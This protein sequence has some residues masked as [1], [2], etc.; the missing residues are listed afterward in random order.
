MAKRVFIIVL[1][2]F[3]IGQ[4]P[5]ANIYGDVGSNTLK[6]IASTTNLNIP[7]LTSLGLFNI[8][9]VSCRPKTDNPLGSYARLEE[10]SNGKDSTTGHWEMAGII[11]KTPFP[12]FKNGFPKSI[13]TKLEKAWNK[14]ILCNKP[15]S[16]TQVILDYGCEHIKTGNPIVYTSADSVLQIACHEDII[17][18]ETL[19]SMC[20]QAREIMVGKFGVGRIIARPFLGEYPNF[21]RTANRHD[22]S[23]VPPANNLLEQIINANLEVISIGKIDDMFAHKNIT[24]AL[25]STSN[26]MGMNQLLMCQEQ[27]FSGLCWLNLC[28]FDQKFGHRNDVCGYANALSSFD[29]KLKEFLA[30]M[31]EEDALIIT[32]DHGCD[33]S[34]QSTDHSREYVPFLLYY[35]SI[36]PI[37][38]KTKKGFNHVGATVLNLLNIKSTNLTLNDK[39]NL[40]I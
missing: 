25:P 39:Y 15:Y 9:G 1:D 13:I 6:A 8:E 40:N 30:K 37:N 7:T 33:P 38:L 22:F 23:L 26:E 29:N 36:K 2:S 10:V 34:T 11:T 12:T 19:Y 17:P 24:T 27:D 5:D 3:G 28:D 18:H 21:Y 35:N 20:K 4:A 31:K 16:G 32:A 14:K